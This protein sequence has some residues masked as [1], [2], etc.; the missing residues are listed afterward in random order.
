MRK[1]NIK[2]IN[3]QMFKSIVTTL[4]ITISFILSSCTSS[5]AA[6]ESYTNATQGYQFLYPQGWVQ[7]KVKDASP[8][9]DVVFRDFIERS[10][11]LSVIVSSIPEDQSL[12]DLGTPTEVGYRFFKDIANKANPNRQVEFTNAESLQKGEQIYYL[13]EYQVKLQDNQP[14]HNLASVAVKNGKLYTFNISTTENRWSK[15]NQLLETV[16][17]SFTV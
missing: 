16:V 8:G 12:T 6:L 7:V 17:K 10:E 1:L 3:G 13:L 11:N 2:M 4:I 14:R 5:L 15:I 9:V